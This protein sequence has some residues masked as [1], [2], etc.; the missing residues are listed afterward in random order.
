MKTPST[1]RAGFFNSG[2]VIGFARCSLGLLL[3]LA[4]LSKSVTG[5][6]TTTATAATLNGNWTATGSLLD[7]RYSHTATLLL[8]GKVLVAG[9][10][11]GNGDN[12]ASAEL[13]DPA[14]GTWAAT[15]SL[16]TARSQFTATLLPNGKVLVAGGNH[17]GALASAELYDP[18]SGTWTPTGSLGTARV[19][20]TATLLPNGLVLVAGG[21]NDASAELYDPGLGTWSSTGSLNTARFFHTATL[22]TNGT[23]LVAGG[24]VTSA[25]LYDPGLGTWS[26]TGSLATV[27]AEH[28]ATLLPNGKVLVAGGVDDNSIALASAELY[29]PT[30]TSKLLN[31]S[32]RLRV[33]PDPNELI[34]GFIVTGTVPKKVILRAIGPSLSNANPPVPGALADPTLELHQN[35]GGTDTIIATNDNW[36]DSP[37]QQAIIDSTVAPTDDLESAIVATL[38]PYSSVNLITYTA[39]LRGNNNTTGV[40]LVEGYDLDQSADSVLANLST[41]GFVDAGDNVMIGGIISG[42]TGNVLVRAIG[43]SLLSL[44]IPNPLQDPALELHDGNGGIIASNDNWKSD[45]QSAIEGTGI[46]PTDDNESAILVALAPGNYTAIVSGING[47]MGVGLIEVYSVP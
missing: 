47:G 26:S 17:N 20:H 10:L 3:A 30:A 15:G 23:V 37:D 32:T 41:R 33:Q 22:L 45:Q 25:E 31:V 4:G 7:T 36:K 6:P 5:T 11:N 29:N 2:A 40:A 19:L 16:A 9:G 28:T 1:S 38:Q 14:S 43:P 39:V 8:D 18:A 27:R 12:V 24:F 34:A 46:P 44:G 42:S 35:I 21:I 13:Y